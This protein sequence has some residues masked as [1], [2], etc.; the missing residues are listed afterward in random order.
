MLKRTKHHIARLV[1]LTVITGLTSSIPFEVKAMDNQGNLINSNDITI[2]AKSEKGS[3]TVDKA[4]DGDKETYWE[5]SNHYRWVEIDLGG[6]YTLSQI[7]LF[8][9]VN[10]YYNYNIYASSDGENFIKVADKSD[11]NLATSDG[12]IH[13]LDNI[14]AS[15]LRIDVTF[16]SEQ[17][18]SNIAEIELYGEKISNEKPVEKPIEVKNFND[19][20]W[21]TEYSKFESDKNYANEKTIAEMI[22]MVGRVI[23]EEYKD[24]FEF[25]L[26]KSTLSGHD[27]FEIQDGKDGKILI[28]GNDGV[29]LASGFNYYLKNYAKI[30]YN[31]I[32]GS[33]L[34]MPETLPKVGNKV[35]IDTP[36]EYRYELNFCTYSYTMS[37]W[38]WDEYE[39]FIDWS[40]MNG[41]NVVLDIVGQEEVLRRTLNEFGYTDEEVKEFISGPAYF[42]WFY[43]QNM[44]SFG[45]PLPNNWFEERAELGRQMHDR[46]Q[47]L[48]IKPVLQGYSGMVP[49]DF[50]SKNP[51]AEIIPQGDWCGFDRPNMLKTYVNEGERDYFQEVADV[52][53]EKQ[54]EVFG[55][56]TDFY[57]VDPF[58][59]GGNTGG[60]NDGRI[61]G[62]IQEKMLEHDKDAIWVIQHWQGNPSNSKLNGLVNKEQALILDLNSDLRD[63][64]YK[65]FEGVNVPW[66]WNMLHNF[67]GRMGLDGQ[68]ERLANNIPAAYADSNYMKGIG[69]APEAINNSPIVY[70]LLGDMIWTRDKIDFRQWTY[71]YIERRYGKV[72][73]D[74]KEAWDILLETA[75]KKRDDY[76]QG[77]AESV[78]NSRPGMNINSASTWGNNKIPYDKK[79]LEK[80][81]ELFIKSYEDLKDS[82]AFIYDF[83]DVTKQLLANS[84]Q[85]YHK[86]LVNAYNLRD[87]E[88]FNKISNHFLDLIKLQERVLATS[89]E[90]LVG[91]W[92]DQSR[93]MLKGADDWTKD[94]FEFN[95]RALIT[96]WGDYKNESLKDYSNRQWA[97]L[98]G[99]LYLKRWEMWIDGLRKQLEGGTAPNINWHK[100][101]YEW[102]V[103]K[104]TAENAYPTK[105]S[106]ENLSELATIAMEKFSVTNMNKFLDGS[107]GVVEKE[108]IS[109][110]KPVE[111]SVETNPEYPTSNLTDGTTGTE[112]KAN[113]VTWPVDLTLDLQGNYDIER[114][115]FSPNQAAGGFAINYIVEVLS[116][117]KWV[118][119]GRQDEGTITGTIEIDYKGKAEKV[120]LKLS[121]TNDELVPEMTEIA[122]Y[123]EEAKEEMVNVALNK[124]VTGPDA[125]SGN[126]LSNITDG[127][128]DSLWIANSGNLPAEINVDL[129]KSEY[130][131]KLEIL[132]EKA[133][134][135]FKFKVS[136]IDENGNV[137]TVLDKSKNES[138]LD[139]KYSISVGKDIKGIKFEFTGKANVGQWPGA[140]AALAEIKALTPADKETKFVNVASNKPVIGSA[141]ENGKP[142]SNITDGDLNSLWVSN[143]GVIPA[144][145]TIDLEK[146]VNVDHINLHLEKAGFRFQFKVETESIDGERTVVLD[147]TS[148]TEDNEKTYK[149]PV[150]KNISKIHVTITGKAEGGQ[151]PGA[152][153]AL[154][155]VEAMSKERPMQEVAS[156]AIPQSKM[157]ATATSEHPNVGTEG[158]ASFAIDGNENTI[159]HTNYETSNPLPQSITLNLGG[160]Y[161]VNKFTYLPRRGN[162][163]NGNITK[164]RL[165]VST[166]GESFDSVAEGNL[167]NNSDLKTITFDKRN[168]THVRLTALEGVGGF[169]TASELNVFAVPEN[170]ATSENVTVTATSNNETIGNI[171]DGNMET[172]WKPAVNEEKVVTFDLGSN[173][174]VNGTEILSKDNEA[175]KYRIEYSI[176]NDIWNTLVDNT[177]NKESY[178]NYVDI[179]ESPVL[180]RYIKVTF[181]NENVDISEL[182]IY[183]G[184][185]S[186]KLTSHINKAESIYNNAVTGEYAGD[187][188]E[189]AKAKLGESIE[190][191]KL[192]VKNGLNSQELDAEISKLKD[193]VKEFYKGIVTIDRTKLASVLSDV[194]AIL[195]SIDSEVINTLNAE[196]RAV[197]ETALNA[198]KAQ[199]QSA[200]AVYE[201][202]RVTQRELDEAEMALKAKLDEYI[203]SLNSETAYKTVLA[204]AKSKIES[205]VVGEGNGQYSQE[206]VD[207]LNAVITKAEGDFTEATEIAV[208][209]GITES[210]KL[211]ISEFEKSIIVVNTEELQGLINSAKELNKEDYTE[212]SWKVLENAL[213]SAEAILLKEGVTQNEVDSSKVALDEAINSLQDKEENNIFKRHLEIAVE[214]ADKVTEDELSKVVPAVVNEFRSALSEAKELLENPSAT[215][216]Q[217]DS[218]FDRLSKAMHMLSFNKG[219]KTHLVALVTKISA[220]DSNEYIK[221]T[222]DKLIVILEKANKVIADENALE[223]E[224]STTYDEL[225]KG[226]LDLRL[227]PSKEKLESLINKVEKL[228]SSKYTKESWAVLQETLNKAKIVMENEEA[229]KEEIEKATKELTVA[230]NS[231]V[232]AEVPPT[233]G[234]NNN[235]NDGSSGNSGNSENTNGNNENSSG[236]GSNTS[237]SNGKLPTTGGASPVLSLV[238]GA[239]IAAAGG[240]TLKKKCKKK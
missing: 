101:E 207:K 131:E 236:N 206:S 16:S 103:Q 231:L 8:N 97:G 39:A 208:I 178:G 173:K 234:E 225:L 171:K 155:E 108:N 177:S 228:D 30:M 76:Y 9:K 191:A 233:N 6:T 70:E 91:T 204:L 102:A 86:E 113:G 149:I 12:D 195:N 118:E 56:V 194:E 140:W 52:F 232:K 35:V 92:I 133:G 5:S 65:R 166:D 111:S 161:E 224:V 132:F 18:D 226:F 223:A 164:Y 98:T 128:E 36:Y 73:E 88:K 83:L 183:K 182:K 212:T 130:I 51:D 26:R 59:E 192:A 147:K 33:N 141:S 187:Y 150:R 81:V 163:T 209:D 211:A 78:I 89:P 116:D 197:L 201:T 125:Q 20:K 213:K 146:E 4:M 129:T 175:L 106:E 190:A 238:L 216:N 60:L 137:E 159:W 90:F 63:N 75:Y 28:K 230:F 221:E 41:F 2:T 168:A 184:D 180:A 84:S 77:A 1:A 154:A 34:N 68:P 152:W 143:N 119:V 176:D 148:N 200:S 162:S 112:W 151:F 214:E 205:A 174:D 50:K 15:K 49:L 99:D 203:S 54:K 57:G 62:T 215:Q 21:S 240:L 13:N 10:G 25:E 135:P 37:F 134:L 229:N 3:N 219:D 115:T 237:N 239:S 96:T 24:K 72:N 114:I 142:L 74:I 17:N 117:G 181:E 32:M 193:A 139:K 95:A 67:G 196:E 235:G 165:E 217:I 7:K 61:Y 110:G 156:V 136:T 105:G 189:E 55:D 160:E 198:L 42:A 14:T 66:V 220:L 69:I 145:A 53:Y 109:L 199:H 43:M 82:D 186:Y 169:A 123:G 71:D 85:E 124:P 11:K 158:L 46:M 127:N 64:D 120:R 144:N 80:S 157:S 19:T 222:W 87:L 126:P 27:V 45:G 172:S 138:E 104:T 218:S 44:T 202:K 100:V 107:S 48:G 79:E 38:D 185:V 210:L 40:A 31:P 58:H 93:T 170:F 188:T 22:N 94:L 227:K 167:D 23:G 179:A 47:T 122:V 153:A 29:S 121:S